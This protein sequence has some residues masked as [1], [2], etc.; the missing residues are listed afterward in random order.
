M[1]RFRL[2]GAYS[3][4][5]QTLPPS[6]TSTICA[7]DCAA[8]SIPTVSVSRHT[9]HLQSHAWG[10][11]SSVNSHSLCD[12]HQFSL[13]IDQDAPHQFDLTSVVL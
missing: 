8:H 10:I 5:N 1:L 12:V 9:W 2:S 6:S 11:H 13:N 3:L 7:A 4:N